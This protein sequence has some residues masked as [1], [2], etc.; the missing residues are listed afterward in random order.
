MKATFVHIRENWS[1]WRLDL[2]C[3]DSGRDFVCGVEV[4]R[5]RAGRSSQPP[6]IEPICCRAKGEGP[7]VAFASAL[8]SAGAA[9]AW[10]VV[11]GILVILLLMFILVCVVNIWW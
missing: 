9:K 3:G 1:A 4:A 6:T 11:L 10:V 8:G 5:E 7:R 2:S